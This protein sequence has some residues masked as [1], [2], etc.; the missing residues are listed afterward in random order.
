MASQLPTIERPVF[1]S[2]IPDAF[3]AAWNDGKMTIT[4]GRFDVGHI[5]NYASGVTLYL[6]PSR[7]PLYLYGKPTASNQQNV[8]EWL[9]LIKYVPDL[10]Q[11]LHRSKA[12]GYV[13][14]AT[15]IRP[16][17]WI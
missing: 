3:W 1:L 10:M 12:G 8:H 6:R 7:T 13:R 2:D 15:G 5:S 11:R 14:F 16:G 4:I 17:V 9:W